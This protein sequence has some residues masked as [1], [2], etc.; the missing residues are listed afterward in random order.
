MPNVLPPHRLPPDSKQWGDSM[1]RRQL[2]VEKQLD[3]TANDTNNALNLLQSNVNLLN[4]QIGDISGRFVVS[5][6]TNNAGNQTGVFNVSAAPTGNSVHLYCDD[7]R[8]VQ[9][10]AMSS[11][12]LY[13]CDFQWEY[14]IDGI[15]IADIHP[16]IPS[17]TDAGWFDGYIF[18]GTGNQGLQ[19]NCSGFAVLMLKPGWHTISLAY[20]SVSNGGVS[21]AYMNNYWAAMYVSVYG[22]SAGP[23]SSGS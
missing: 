12:Y 5:N 6:V 1:S 22:Y 2:D 19:V 15:V 18:N 9:I 4:K 16:S 3:R 20:D 14:M 10:N 17:G 21:N 13:A 8:Y 7:I 11:T 23:T